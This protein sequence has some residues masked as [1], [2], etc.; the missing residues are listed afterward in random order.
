MNFSGVFE[1]KF[2]KIINFIGC[3]T[4]F[5]YQLG[6]HLRIQGKILPPDLLVSI[7][8]DSLKGQPGLIQ[9]SKFPL[10]VHLSFLIVL[11]TKYST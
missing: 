3:S 6:Y 7:F 2:G 11:F 5:I 10:R 1:S 9:G 8:L 4:Q